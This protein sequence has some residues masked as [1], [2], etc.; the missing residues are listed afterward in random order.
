MP[1][2]LLAAGDNHNG[3]DLTPSDTDVLDWFKAPSS[4]LPITA[5]LSQR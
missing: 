5:F 1:T 4:G 2:D 3:G